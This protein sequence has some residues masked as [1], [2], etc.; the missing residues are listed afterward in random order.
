M[1]FL[2]KDRWQQWAVEW[3]LTHVPQK[4]WLR[5]TERVLGQRKGLLFR[6]L[7]GTD[8]SPG[9]HIC[10]RFPRV[11]DLDRVR[12]A[13][14]ADSALDVLPSKGSARRKMEI[15]T[16]SAPRVRFTRLPEFR[17]GTDAL[18]WRRAFL[19]RTPSAAQIQSW[20]DAL[21]ESLARATPTFG[22]K[23]ESCGTGQAPS[24][25]VVDGMPMMLCTTCQQKLRLEGE[26]A[27]RAY[28]M[29]EA[30]HVNGLALAF[31][32]SLIGGAAWA[33]VA[34]LTHRIFAMGAIGI[35]A[36]V[37]FA[38]RRGAGRVDMLGRMIAAGLTL[39][40]V[41]LGQVAFYAWV[42]EQKF[43]ELG[44]NLGLGWRAYMY[45]WAK[46]PGE[47]IV[48]MFFAL[49]GAWF[50]TKALEKPKLAH[51]IEGAAASGTGAQRKA[52]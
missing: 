17:L 18:L 1:S 15:Q 39:A 51:Q 8:E 24:Y 31:V 13:L 43:P 38:Y 32:A 16:G 21:V 5:R 48:P 3:G 46:T 6:V 47:E 10:V 25:V 42:V 49:V 40:S 23:C 45:S 9:L 27:E 35:G 20:V 19:F 12:A 36:L 52:A 29:T 50:A 14:I 37:A 11:T 26:L 28:E 2:L 30:R 4:G 34:V 22:G 33:A 7:W 41:M 44:F